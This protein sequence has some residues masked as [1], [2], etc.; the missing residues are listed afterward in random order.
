LLVREEVALNHPEYG[1][2]A[3]AANDHLP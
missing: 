2:L 1:T 3:K